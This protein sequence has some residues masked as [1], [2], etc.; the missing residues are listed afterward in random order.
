MTVL[1]HSLSELMASFPHR[2]SLFLGPE[3]KSTGTDDS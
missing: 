2:K 1:N 3:E